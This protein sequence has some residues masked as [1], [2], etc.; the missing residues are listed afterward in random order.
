MSAPFSM[1]TVAFTPA[2]VSVRRNSRTRRRGGA[3][4]GPAV[5]LRGMRLT[6][7]PPPRSSSASARACA[8]A[9]LTP[10]MSAYS[11]ETRRPVARK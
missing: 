8:G 2:S 11:M 9:S 10:P 1:R 4:N 6:C 3:A 5:G 7:M